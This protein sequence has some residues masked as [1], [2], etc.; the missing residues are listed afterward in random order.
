MNNIK[1]HYKLL[2]MICRNYHCTDF[3]LLV[4]IVCITYSSTISCLVI[5]SFPFVFKIS[6]LFVEIYVLWS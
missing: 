6:L 5:F 1:N 2:T 3:V 4:V